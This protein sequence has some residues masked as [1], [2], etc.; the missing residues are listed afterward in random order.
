MHKL[1]DVFSKVV[2]YYMLFYEIVRATSSAVHLK[3]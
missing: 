3:L 2:T 1:I